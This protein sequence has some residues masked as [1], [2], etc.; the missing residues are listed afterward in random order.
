MR[1]TGGPRRLSIG[2]PNLSARKGHYIPRTAYTGAQRR[3]DPATGP[4]SGL[5]SMACAIGIR[6]GTPDAP[7][8]HNGAG[9]C[10]HRL[11][12][13]AGAERAP[14]GTRRAGVRDVPGDSGRV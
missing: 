8:K 7:A 1:A 11:A 3:R 14:A 4:R 2:L 6:T 12:A 13:A 9:P 10:V 5:E